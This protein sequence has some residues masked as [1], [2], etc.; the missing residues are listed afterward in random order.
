[1]VLYDYWVKK[2]ENMF[3]DLISFTSC[4]QS[5]Y[6]F[7]QSL[8][9]TSLVMIWKQHGDCECTNKTIPIHRQNNKRKTTVHYH[10]HTVHVTVKSV[11]LLSNEGENGLLFSLTDADGVQDLTSCFLHLTSPWLVLQFARVLELLRAEGRVESV[12]C[13]THC[14]HISNNIPY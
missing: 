9:S 4:L 2:H 1:M 10:T 13:L 14:I 7:F 6:F 12:I 3:A 8:A 11:Y 5:S